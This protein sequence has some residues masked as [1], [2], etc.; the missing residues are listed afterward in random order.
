V[1]GLTVVVSRFA[2]A[3]GQKQATAYAYPRG[4]VALSLWGRWG[5]AFAGMDAEDARRLA[6]SLMDAADL[7]ERM[8]AYAELREV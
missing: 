2:E 3:W 5:H 8:E 7:A 1:K 4:R 6:W